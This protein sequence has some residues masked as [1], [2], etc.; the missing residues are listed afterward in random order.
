M[1]SENSL[2]ILKRLYL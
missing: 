1:V 2:P